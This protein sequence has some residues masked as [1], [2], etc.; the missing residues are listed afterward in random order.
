MSF[1]TQLGNP[2]LKVA[3]NLELE[4]WEEL[5]AA[6]GHTWA[7]RGPASPAYRTTAHFRAK[8]VEVNGEPL[9]EVFD[10]PS[11]EA[12]EGT[13]LIEDEGL[14][15]SVHLTG[16]K[17]PSVSPEDLLLA[18]HWEYYTTRQA[19]PPDAIE[20]DGHW[21][22]PYVDA[23]A[24]PDLEVSVADFAAGGVN[25]SFGSITLSNADGHFD[26]RIG[27]LNYGAIKCSLQVGLVGDA[28]ADF[29]SYW[30]GWTGKITAD[31]LKISVEIESLTRFPE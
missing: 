3:L 1:L 18:F 5:T 19:D 21:F 30:D 24:I 14:T 31:D 8:R 17:N 26:Q 2:D 22:L 13:F 12:T 23:D 4:P 11:L 25:A 9:V 28:H 29:M 20:Y 15:V 6:A 7:I 16:G 10:F 27:H